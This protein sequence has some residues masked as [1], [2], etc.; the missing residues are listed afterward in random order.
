MPMATIQ[1]SR[2]RVR[3]N[4]LLAG[5]FAGAPQIANPDTITRDEEER[6]AAYVGAG[7][8]YASPSRAEPWL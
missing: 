1:R 3:V 5:Q 6:V 8:L 7:T 4:A 2:K